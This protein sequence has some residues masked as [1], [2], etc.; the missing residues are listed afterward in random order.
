VVDDTGSVIKQ[1]DYDSFGNILTDTNPGF[2][3]PF[4]FAGGMAD[5]AHELVRF[6]ARDYQPS[7]GR[8]TAKDPILFGGGAHLYGYVGNDPVNHADRTGLQTGLEIALVGSVVFLAGLLAAVLLGDRICALFHS[9]PEQPFDIQSAVESGSRYEPVTV[10]AA[11]STVNADG[12]I[13]FEVDGQAVTGFVN[14]P[15]Q[16]TIEVTGASESNIGEG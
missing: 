8:W 5:P 16:R 1:V 2:D 7:A 11:D 13:S 14:L 6:G 12:T 4:G 10:S 9:Q 15:V 3:L